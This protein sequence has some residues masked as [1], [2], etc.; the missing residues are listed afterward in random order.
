MAKGLTCIIHRWPWTTCTTCCGS[1]YLFSKVYQRRSYLIQKLKGQRAHA[2]EIHAHNSH[3]PGK[4]C[5][6]SAHRRGRKRVLDGWRRSSK[7]NLRWLKIWSC[8]SPIDSYLLSLLC[9]YGFLWETWSVVLPWKIQVCSP[10]PE[11]VLGKWAIPEP[12]QYCKTWPAF[13][14]VL[15]LKW[16]AF[17]GEQRRND[18][19][20]IWASS[21]KKENK[22]EHTSYCSSCCKPLANFLLSFLPLTKMHFFAWPYSQKPWKP[23]TWP[24][25]DSFSLLAA[26]TRAST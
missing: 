13:S 10:G 24:I 6:S 7:W 11:G 19:E 1:L 22:A 21:K 9:Q 12:E 25:A 26:Y 5:N 23:A 16:G 20:L 17:Y 15:V 2:E 14:G 3:S 18:I 8:F 4:C